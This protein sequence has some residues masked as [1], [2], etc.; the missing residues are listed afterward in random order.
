MKTHEMEVVPEPLEGNPGTIL[1]T[2]EKGPHTIIHGRGAVNCK[3][4]RCG[5]VLCKYIEPV[6]LMGLIFKCPNCDAH[7]R[8]KI[9]QA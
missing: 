7:N 2:R 8:V 3:C 1:R 5:N 6:Q 9:S 4:G